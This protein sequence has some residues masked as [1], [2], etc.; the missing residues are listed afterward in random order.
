[1]GQTASKDLHELRQ[2]VE[3]WRKESGGGR[4]TRIPDEI[5]DAAVRVAEAEG[6]NATSRELRF[7]Y[8]RLK[9]RV[10]GARGK[11][12]RSVR[13]K[14]AAAKRSVGD[15]ANFVALE[16]SGAEKTVIEL[17]GARGQKM[18][19]EAVCTKADVITLAQ[20]FLEKS[21]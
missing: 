3:A 1:M 16:L 8:E 7:N 15:G 18:R 13:R 20:A 11:K 10:D 9:K 12:Q 6:V 17:V 19:I 2:R 14:P 5:W 21:R 4:G